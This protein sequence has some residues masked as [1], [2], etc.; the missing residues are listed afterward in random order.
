LLVATLPSG[1][2]IPM[3]YRQAELRKLQATELRKSY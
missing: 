1:L 3:W 2:M